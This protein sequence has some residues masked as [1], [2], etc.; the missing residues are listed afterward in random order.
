MSYLTSIW[1]NVGEVSAAC[2]SPEQTGA[3]GDGQGRQ[4][5]SLPLHGAPILAWPEL[6]ADN[7]HLNLMCPKG[8]KLSIAVEIK[9]QMNAECVNFPLISPNNIGT[10]HQPLALAWLVLTPGPL[11]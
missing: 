2:V 10:T 7:H 1:D 3:T 5:W 4:T 8:S 6:R 9:R 11:P